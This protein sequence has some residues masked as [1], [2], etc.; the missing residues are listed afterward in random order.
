[1]TIS[2]STSGSGIIVLLKTLKEI[3]QNMRAPNV[4]FVHGELAYMLLL[5]NQSK[6]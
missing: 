3:S 1:M 5:V 2:Y 4:F 6:F